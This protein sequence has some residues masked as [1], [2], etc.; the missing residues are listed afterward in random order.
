MESHTIKKE[1]VRSGPP[2]D[3]STDNDREEV[4][5]VNVRGSC[6]DGVDEKSSEKSTLDV[7]TLKL[8]DGILKIGHSWNVMRS[9]PKAPTHD[10]CGESNPR[11]LDHCI[12]LGKWII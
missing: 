9:L 5:T 10:Q 6:N 3:L 8:R 4:S 12:R 7:A 2:A 11:P 1:V